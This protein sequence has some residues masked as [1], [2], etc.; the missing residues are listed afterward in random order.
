MSPRIGAGSDAVGSASGHPR[1]AGS[2]QRD[3]D[4][5][6]GAVAGVEEGPAG[7]DGFADEASRQAEADQVAV[8]DGAETEALID[9]ILPSWRSSVA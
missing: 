1:Q 4:C 2:V 6:E 8:G 5:A 3:G 7:A 9:E